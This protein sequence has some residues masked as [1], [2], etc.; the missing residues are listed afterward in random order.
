M[1]LYIR[2]KR[3]TSYVTFPAF[4]KVCSRSTWRRKLAY[5]MKK[6]FQIH[7]AFCDD[8]AYDLLQYSFKENWTVFQNLRNHAHSVKKDSY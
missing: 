6:I 1:A 4:G 2:H 7:R 8:S 3:E 5:F